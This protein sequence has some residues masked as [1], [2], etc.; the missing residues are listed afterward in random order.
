MTAPLERI[1]VECSV[2]DG[3]GKRS[4]YQPGYPTYEFVHCESCDGTGYGRPFLL[5]QWAIEMAELLRAY[6]E[7]TG[8]DFP[9]KSVRCA[10]P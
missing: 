3:T 7:A 1:E 2:C 8:K 5:P 6:R 4:T 9:T 10:R